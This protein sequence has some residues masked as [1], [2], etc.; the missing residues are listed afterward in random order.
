MKKRAAKPP[1]TNCCGP[2]V[3]DA[4]ELAQGLIRCKSVTPDEGGALAFIESV[5]KPLGFA[6][7]RLVFSEPGT[8]DVENLYARWGTG[9]PHFCF[10]GHTDVVPTGDESGWSFD[11]FGGKILNG[12]LCGR[13]ACDMKGAIGAFMAAAADFIAH[14]KPQG[15]ISLLITGDEEGPAVNGTKKALEWMAARGETPDFCVVGEPT[16]DHIPG[17]VIKIGRR[18]SLYGYLSVDGTE[19]HVAYPQLADNPVPGMVR[20]LAALEA[21]E[22]DAG[23]ERFDPSNLEI[24]SLSTAPGSRNSIP[25][26]SRAVFAVR[27]N[28]TYTLATLESK[29][30]ATLDACAVPYALDVHPM[31][32]SFYTPQ[33]VHS[34]LVAAAAEAVTGV[35]P[36]FSTSG[37]T[38]D[39]RFIRNYCPVVELGV[40][41]ATAH[42]TDERVPAAHIVQLSGIYIGI[43]RR[44]FRG[45]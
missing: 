22:L 21:L 17:D 11:P 4:V 43:L 28:D 33:G 14:E 6:C 2:D 34:A 36:A 8:P 7:H 13:G 24:V 38:S 23:T 1:S 32:E 42:K 45:A 41:N 3:A 15:S 12:D 39:A 37:G 18:G 10:A 44:F 40:S 29:I 9:A 26:W 30:R 25:A 35:K 31:S 19:G 27:F 20:L 5:L 16:A